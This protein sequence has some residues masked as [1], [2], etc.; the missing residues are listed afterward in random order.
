MAIDYDRLIAR[1]LP[2]IQQTYRAKDTMLYALGL[3]LGGNPLDPRELAF[4]YED[5][6]KIFP[7]MPQILGYPGFWAQEADTGIDW[8]KLVHGEQSFVLHKALPAEGKIVAKNRVSALYD[9]GEGKGAVLCQERLV[10]DAD[11]EELL[12]TVQQV[13]LLR[14]DGGFGGPSGSPPLAHT[15]PE[16]SPDASLDLST[17]PQLALIYRLSGDANPLHADPAVAKG[18]GFERPILHGMATMGIACHALLRAVLDYRSEQIGG[19]RVRFSAP[20]LP[21]E[22][23]RTEIWKDGDVLSFRAWAVERNALVLNNG[24]I[25]LI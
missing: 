21:G 2:T 8:R 9:K 3:G 12:V 17:P 14:G 13:S 20:F 15:I 25:E 11:T 19:M 4:V 18:A 10:Y 1:P 5:G 6:L 22:T 16:R 24:R 7:T 23:L